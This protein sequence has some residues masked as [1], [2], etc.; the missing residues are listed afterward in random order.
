LN[1]SE[2]I[3]SAVSSIQK[4][5]LSFVINTTHVTRGEPPAS[6]SRGIGKIATLR[7][8]RRQDTKALDIEIP[9]AVQ[10]LPREL[11]NAVAYLER[12]G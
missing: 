6:L 9:A 2:L 12:P 8:F 3:R 7:Y 1:E 5:C 11:K 4:R 10:S